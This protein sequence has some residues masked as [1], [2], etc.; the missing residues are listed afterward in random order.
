[1]IDITIFLYKLVILHCFLLVCSIRV[2][3]I[4]KRYKNYF[5]YT[6]KFHL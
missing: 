5:V 1:M 6:L 2:H 4:F 3:Y